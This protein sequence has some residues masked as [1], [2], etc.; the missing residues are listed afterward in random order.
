MLLVWRAWWALQVRLRR[1][2]ELEAR[3]VEMEVLICLEEEH[4]VTGL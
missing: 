4:G 1:Y 3:G 2:R